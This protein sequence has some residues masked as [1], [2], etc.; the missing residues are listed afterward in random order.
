MRTIITLSTLI[1]F[2]FVGAQNFRTHYIR[3]QNSTLCIEKLTEFTIKNNFIDVSEVFAN[4]GKI[5]IEY[6]CRIYDSGY[7]ENAS[8]F[9]A[10]SPTYVLDYYGKDDYNRLPYHVNIQVI[11]DKKG[12]EVLYVILLNIKTNR[13]ELYLTEN[14]NFLCS[15]IIKK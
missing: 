3:P 14:M 13:H 8:Y 9:E 7:T 10:Y 2:N 5:T 1:L 11:Y 6:P 15:E 12:G 4:G